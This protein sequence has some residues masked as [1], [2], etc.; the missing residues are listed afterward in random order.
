[1][2]VL[3][4][5]CL[6]ISGGTRPPAESF[7]LAAPPAWYDHLFDVP[8]IGLELDLACMGGRPGPFGPLRERGTSARGGGGGIGGLA[9]GAS[10]SRLGRG[11]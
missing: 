3:A 7:D 2:S 8:Q 4:M 1:M 6:E 5:D 9:V 11:N 10:D